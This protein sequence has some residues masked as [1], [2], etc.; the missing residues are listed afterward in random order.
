MKIFVALLFFASCI[1]S[2]PRAATPGASPES[3]VIRFDVSLHERQAQRVHIAMTLSDRPGDFVDVSMPVW[4]PGSYLVREYA[5]H[6]LDLTATN[7]RGETLTVEK[8]T[9]NTWRVH[10]GGAATVTIDYT[11]YCNERSVRTNHVDSSHAFL[12]PA[13]TF[14]FL[15]D[16]LDA[17]YRVS[18]QRPGGWR[19]FTGMPHDEANDEFVADHY[20][21]LVDCPLEIGPHEPLTFEHEGVSHHIVM[22]GAVTID[23]DQLVEDFK[24]IVA[25]VSSIFGFLP[26]DEY[27]FL[28]IVVDAGGGGLEHKNSSVNM[29]S[30]WRLADKKG[31]RGFL[32]L[33][34]HEYFHAWNVKRFRPASLGPFDYDRENYTRDLWVAEGIT[35]YVDDRTVVR[36]GF[37]DDV[38]GYLS[39][40][41]QGFRTL[42]EQPGARRMSLTRSS[43]DAWIKHYRPD[44]NQRNSAISYYSKGAL[45]ALMLDLRIRRLTMGEKTL[46]DAL[47]LGWEAYTAK[48]EGF[49]DGSMKT[50]VER[51]TDMPFDDFFDDYIDG[52]TPLEPNPDLAWVGLQLT[53]KPEKTDRP[54]TK[55]ADGFPL[56]PTL[57]VTVEGSN[58][59]ARVRSVTEGG[60]AYFA[61][62]NVDDVLLAIR[63]VR[64]TPS[65]LQERLDM[66]GHQPLELTYYRGE[67]LLTTT[68]KPQTERLAKWVIASVDEPTEQQL[69]AFEDWLNWPHPKASDDDEDEDDDSEDDEDDS[70]AQAGEA[71]KDEEKDGV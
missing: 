60:A 42:A 30:R 11:L 12:A 44:E 25:E 48:G 52:T 37:A 62:I 7:G 45:V 71:D 14:L 63:D 66:A 32:S 22:A 64:I 53:V 50:F 40:R 1:T 19:V 15:R 59:L 41:A 2:S 6:V 23:E 18:V 9:K 58:G 29:I 67:S 43:H 54:L 8:M 46:H 39:D 55:D 27:W 13:A 3:A 65:T 38:K 34:A 17:E 20:D 69:E 33:I 16:H 21:T 70:E 51:T 49:P 57:G 56:A 47:R 61:G 68:I 28:N 5:R 10:H 35:S 36:A 31:Y 26:F 24:A 4:T